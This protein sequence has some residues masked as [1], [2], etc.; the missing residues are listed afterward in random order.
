[1]VDGR[2]LMPVN[3]ACGMTDGTGKTKPGLIGAPIN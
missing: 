3:I 1:M 2:F